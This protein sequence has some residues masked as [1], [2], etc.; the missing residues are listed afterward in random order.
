MTAPLRFSHSSSRSPT[1]GACCCWARAPPPLHKRGP[2]QP[3][4]WCLRQA[5][6]R[7]W[8]WRGLCLQ[9]RTPT[10]GDACIMF[11]SD[12]LCAL[13]R[14]RFLRG[15]CFRAAF[16]RA[17]V[18]QDASG[19]GVAAPRSRRGWCLAS[20]A[21]LRKPRSCPTERRSCLP[22]VRSSVGSLCLSLVRCA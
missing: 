19:V 10:R 15:Q 17:Y 7:R 20:A 5:R 21:G 18:F 8:W 16:E 13:G 6:T 12:F 1:R 2:P 3:L 11:C 4:S 22:G 9:T 14:L